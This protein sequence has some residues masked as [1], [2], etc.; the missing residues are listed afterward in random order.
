V[1][2][3]QAIRGPDPWDELAARLGTDLFLDLQPDPSTTARGRGAQLRRRLADALRDAIADGR[4]PAGTT[5]PPYRSLAA[6][7]GLSRG[8][9]TAVYNELVAEGRLIARQGSGTT[10]AAGA[11]RSVESPGSHVPSATA[12]VRHDFSLG[13]PNASLFPRA[14]WVAA[15]RRALAEAPD[16]VF[17][18]SPPNGSE[19]L[20]TELAHYLSRA[21]GVR[22]TPDRIVLT[23]SVMS[24]LE[25]L[26]RTVLGRRIAVEGYGLPFHRDVIA[27]QGVSIEP[28][29]V[30]HHGAVVEDLVDR[31]V[32]AVL[33]TPSH[34]FPLGVALEPDRRRQ[35]IEWARRSDALII[36]DDYDGELRYDREPVGALQGLAPEQVIYVG[37]VSK[38]LSPAVRIGWIVLPPRLVDTVMWAKGIREPDAS[39]VDQLVLADMIA[40]GAYDKH[41][42]R[43]RQ[44][45]RRRRDTLIT[46]LAEQGIT[47]GGIPAGLHAVVGMGHDAESRVLN[48]G[49]D[50]GFSLVGLD[51]LRHPDAPAVIDR[52]GNPGGG[53]LV[54]FG[55]PAASTFDTDVNALTELITNGSPPG[56]LE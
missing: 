11:A 53:I 1:T 48:A 25:L 44:F 7:V 33:L 51:S 6:D 16:A 20:R 49:W 39:V 3:Q 19:R 55:T 28:I 40:T 10:V 45:Y 34:Q 32:S 54:G 5:L 43:S 17:G 52:D 8:T 42:R 50:R 14:E 56:P 29:P 18:P 31:D 21:R 35:V 9:V 38:S 4:L 27:R 37:S 26:G 30:D 15:T 22:T 2:D 36:E 46:R 12:S 23:T 41:I 24:A 13:Q 47:V